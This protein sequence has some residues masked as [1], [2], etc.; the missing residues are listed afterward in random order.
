MR[1]G[2]IKSILAQISTLIK[3]NLKG[4]IGEG[5]NHLNTVLTFERDDGNTIVHRPEFLLR[6]DLENIIY[7]C[8]AYG[9]T[10]RVRHA[11]GIF[12]A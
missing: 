4:S 12:R 2:I 1:I 11:K 6:F 9:R 7:T 5:M 8:D 10:L 3:R